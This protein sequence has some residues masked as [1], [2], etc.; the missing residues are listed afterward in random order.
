M[1][2]RCS[3]C[4]KILGEKPPLEDESTTDGI[5]QECKERVLAEWE[6]EKGGQRQVPGDLH[7]GLASG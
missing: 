5:C 1:I 6:E 2:I 4:K 7:H 3:W